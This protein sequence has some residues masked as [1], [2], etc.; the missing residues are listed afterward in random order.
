MKIYII[1]MPGSGKTTIGKSLAQKLN[2][3]FIDLDSYIEK[4]N[5][6]FIDDIFKNYGEEKFRDLETEALK[7]IKGEKIV[8]STGG[9]I[10]VKKRNKDLMKGLKIY[11]NTNID[12]IEKRLESSYL[13]PLL[14][15]HSLNDLYQQ[16]FL[17]YQSFADYNVSN[18]STLDDTLKSILKIIEDYKNDNNNN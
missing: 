3:Q 7:N 5:L 8:I 13:R 9:G 1:G 12:I 4:T 17:K 10:I 6:M 2:Y 18:N 15:K 11:L 16:R 14:A